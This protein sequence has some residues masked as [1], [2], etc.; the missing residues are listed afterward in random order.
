[1]SSTVR[2]MSSTVRIMSCLQLLGIVY[3]ILSVNTLLTGFGAK[4]NAPVLN[5]CIEQ[6]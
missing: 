6:L 2:I 5:I 4:L 1:M 3:K